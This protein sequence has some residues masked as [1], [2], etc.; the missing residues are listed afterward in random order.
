MAIIVAYV[1]GW[2]IQLVHCDGWSVSL[3]ILP[4][5]NSLDRRCFVHAH[6]TSLKELAN[7]QQIPGGA[8]KY[9]LLRR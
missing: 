6:Y 5:D 7:A 1:P 2:V 8:L 4:S 9:R 3:S